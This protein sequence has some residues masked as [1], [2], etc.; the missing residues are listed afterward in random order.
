MEKT[1]VLNFIAVV[2]SIIDLINRQVNIVPTYSIS[3]D[4]PPSTVMWINGRI[5]KD[6]GFSDLFNLIERLRERITSSD[7][8]IMK[9]PERPNDRTSDILKQIRSYSTGDFSFRLPSSGASD[10]TD[11]IAEAL[12]N[13]GDRLQQQA[14]AVLESEKQYKNL[15]RNNPMPMWVLALPRLNFLDV[16]ESAI[17][18]YGYTRE[19]FLAMTAF[20]IR[21]EE[22]KERFAKLDRSTTF[23]AGIWKHRRKDGTIIFVQIFVHDIVFDGQP[24][25]LILS[26]DVTERKKA[27]DALR[28]SEARFRR[29]FDS[30]MIGFFFWNT[31]GGITDANDFFLEYVG[32]TRDDLLQGKL[33]W[34]NLTPPEFASLDEAIMQQVRTHGV[35]EPTEKEYIHKNGSRLPVL[36]GAASLSATEGVAYIMDI[37]Q[38]KHMEEE[39]LQLNR[40]LEER[41]A[42]R[43]EQLQEVNK[44][45][46]SFS[47]TVSH[48]LRAP[49]RAIIG[50]S[51]MLLEDYEHTL[52]KEAMRLINTV[53]F[54]AKRMGQLVDDLLEFSRMG[55][56]ELNVA[57]IDMT[58][59]AENV[60]K[61]ITFSDAERSIIKIHP[62][63]TARADHVLMQHVFQ[64]LIMNAIKY[65]SKKPK[66]SVEVDTTTINNE[67]VYLVKDNGAGFDMAYYNKLFGVFQRLHRQDEFEGTGV[68]LAIVHR[69]IK[70]HGGRIWA[71]GKINEGAVFYFTLGS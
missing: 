64:N 6:V 22:E 21:S 38:R 68:G 55:K 63:G 67:K 53:T 25:R 52:D 70:R 66:P 2:F 34:Q 23:N 65:S 49:L 57:E 61:D 4:E 9:G 36:V 29:L 42:T 41:I 60:V 12:N 37:S 14:K 58:T 7:H 8:P 62:L 31:E 44:E 24:G 50:Y 18:Q 16:N 20:D 69:I 45:L 27:V 33:Q 11:E 56:R 5:K 71:E 35:S 28:I 51:Q 30:R 26:V 3:S 47:Y 59:L 40:D 46:E 48:D 54:N 1:I 15:F 10:E 17:S 19:E 13:L 43:T 32:Y 39:I